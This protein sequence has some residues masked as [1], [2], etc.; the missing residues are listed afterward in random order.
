MLK[1]LFL[2]LAALVLVTATF[3]DAR[4]QADESKKFEV[5]GQ[6]ALLQVDTWNIL[7]AAPF[8]VTTNRETVFG[9]GG[10]FGYN[11]SSNFAVEAE[12]NFFPND[13][14]LKA[15]RKTQA[16]FGVRAGKRF[17]KVGVFAKARPGFIR[18]EKGDY[19]LAGGCLTVFPTP[20]A[21][22]DSVAR[23]N[24]AI[25]LGGVVEFYPSTRTIIRVD[26]GDTIVRHP[27]RIVAAS[28]GSPGSNLVT[29]LAAVPVPAETRHQFQGSVG[30][31]FRF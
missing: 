14:E 4:A 30:F 10:R 28:T 3:Y 6:V 9:F 7:P 24:F 12:L 15:G 1:Q 21:C 27:A 22:Y 26:A 11:I 17:D 20:L 23:T 18:Y 29:Y 31:G 2:G 16:L 8:P 19:F 5:G 13:D 25:D